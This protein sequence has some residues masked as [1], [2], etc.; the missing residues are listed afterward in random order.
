MRFCEDYWRLNVVSIADS[1]PM[2]HI[3]YWIDQ[4]GEA[5]FANTLALTKGFS[6]VPLTGEACIKSASATPLGSFNSR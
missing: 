6:K 2:P 3:E 5:W 1:Y 4:I